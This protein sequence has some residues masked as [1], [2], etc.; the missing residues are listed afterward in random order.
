VRVV[1]V[2]SLDGPAGLV[3]A[4]VAEPTGSGVVIDVHAAGVSFPDLLLSRGRYQRKPDLPFVPGVEVAGVVRGAPAGATVGAGDR[5]VAFTWLGGWAETV[6]A[7][8][9][10]TFPLPDRLSMRAGAGIVLNYLTAHLALTRRATVRPGTTVIVHGAAGGLGTALV[11]VA[12]ALGARPIAVVS[13]PAKADIAKASGAEAA[14][15]A[16]SWLAETRSLVGE[17]DVVADPVGGD[18]FVDSLRILRAEGCLL[19][20]GFAAGEIPSVPANRLLLKN[21]DVRGVAWGSLVER[22]PDYPARQWP[23]LLDYVEA[24]HVRPVDGRTFPLEK[25]ADALHELA[26]RTATGKITLTVR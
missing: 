21:I 3:V 18:R 15:R 11:Q 17:V 2:R 24:G 12:A 10:L 20:L 26:N 9:A 19:V 8:P 22:E 7:D 1:Q 6:V 23:D 25:A 5:V 13:T 14:V 4:D 16:E